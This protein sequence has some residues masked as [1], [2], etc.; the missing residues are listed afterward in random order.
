MFKRVDDGG[1]SIHS[2]FEWTYECQPKMYCRPGR[3]ST[4]NGEQVSV[5]TLTRVVPRRILFVSIFL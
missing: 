2:C 4:V 3:C 1:R 5:Y